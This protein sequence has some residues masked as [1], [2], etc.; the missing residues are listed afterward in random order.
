MSIK[1]IAVL[2]V[3]GPATSSALSLDAR[4]EYLDDSKQ[5]KDRLLL[6]HRFNNG[7]GFSVE[8]KFKSGG[9]DRRK[10]MHHMESSS[11][12]FTLSDQF[13]LDANWSLQP[14]LALETS[15]DKETWKPMLR[16]QRDFAN[17]VYIA[18]RYR[19]EYS[20]ISSA[21]AHN[22]HVNRGDVWLGYKWDAWKV[23]Y[24]YLYKHSDQIRFNKG[25][26]D[27][28][29]NIKLGRTLARHWMPYIEV[30]NVSVSKNTRERQT[31]F[32]IGISWNY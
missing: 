14:G 2:L 29:Q 10:P 24:N 21:D 20:H 4:H 1:W 9:D 26:W 17:G 28:E 27:Y 19:Y 11:N 30:G 3:L 16:L 23:E 8:T 6:S 15:S 18:A 22:E 7:I 13:H 12:E 31:R 5:N 32:R 25:R